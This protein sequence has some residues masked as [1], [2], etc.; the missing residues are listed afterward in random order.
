M[1]GQ[2]RCLKVKT[3]LILGR[4][5]STYHGDRQV[6]AELDYRKGE[7]LQLASYGVPQM[8]LT[9]DVSRCPFKFLGLWVIREVLALHITY[10]RGALCIRA[11]VATPLSHL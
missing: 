8:V 7:V 4:G 1:N 11:G 5:I 9:D 6:T 3:S 10:L 2:T